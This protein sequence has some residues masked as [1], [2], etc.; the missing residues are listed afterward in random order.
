VSGHS[1]GKRPAF[2][3]QRRF[4]SQS[5]WLCLQS[6]VSRQQW[7]GATVADDAGRRQNPKPRQ[8]HTCALSNSLVGS[9]EVGA[10]LCAPTHRPAGS[11]RPECSG[12]RCPHSRATPARTSCQSLFS[13]CSDLPFA[14][15]LTR[16]STAPGSFSWWISV[17]VS[18]GPSLRARCSTTLQ[19]RVLRDSTPRARSLLHS[20]ARWC[21]LQHA[22]L[23][24]APRSG[25]ALRRHDRN[26]QRRRQRRGKDYEVNRRARRRHGHRGGRHSADLA[27]VRETRRSWRQPRQHRSAWKEGG[28]PSSPDRQLETKLAAAAI[29]MATVS[30]S[31]L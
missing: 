4:E 10:G 15:S 5:N 14:A 29:S 25:E 11:S 26:Q 30:K 17:W 16:S 7:P 8:R 6:N 24:F 19:R 23:C 31:C 20:P 1:E 18:S 9:T 13:S 3:V 27:V 28:C 2:A 21:C 12:E 22:T